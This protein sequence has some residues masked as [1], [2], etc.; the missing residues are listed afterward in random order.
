[1]LVIVAVVV[2]VS[3]VVWFTVRGGGGPSSTASAARF[4]TL[5]EACSVVS[6]RTVS[7][8]VPRAAVRTYPSQPI[9]AQAALRATQ[10]AARD[11]AGALNSCTA[12]S[13]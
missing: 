1:M 11:V 4:R 13:D 5:P 7:R 10:S 6:E 9:E 12:C 2:S 8:L 3:G